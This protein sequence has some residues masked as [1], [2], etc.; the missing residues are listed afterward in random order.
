[1]FIEGYSRSLTP[2]SVG[3]PDHYREANLACSLKRRFQ[4]NC[5]PAFRNR[6]TVFDHGFLEQFPV[7]SNLYAL[8]SRAENLHV[9]FRKNVA[10][11]KFD[12]TI[13]GCLSSKA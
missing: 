11:C 4:V 1:M 7:V 9:V 5:F 13:E 6:N 2:Q 10:L 8:D 3:D 12:A